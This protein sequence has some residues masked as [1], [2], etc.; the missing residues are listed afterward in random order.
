M[1]KK[2]RA[3][4]GSEITM[5]DYDIIEGFDLNGVNKGNVNSGFGT[6]GNT[7]KSSSKNF[8][9]AGQDYI[10]DFSSVTS[11]QNQLNGSSASANEIVDC[12]PLYDNTDDVSTMV[13]PYGS[14]ATDES[15][16]MFMTSSFQMFY[17]LIIAFIIAFSVPGMYKSYFSVAKR[18]GSTDDIE[19]GN[20]VTGS[21]NYYFM[22]Y[23]FL[24]FL[25]VLLDAGIVTKS[26]TEMSFAMM[27]LLYTMCTYMFTLV[28]RGMMEK[29]DR[30]VYGYFDSNINLSDSL[31]LYGKFM[32]ENFSVTYSLG[33]PII[34][35]AIFIVLPIVFAKDKGM[36][37]LPFGPL[38]A[39]FF[40]GLFMIL[41][42]FG[43]FF[44][45][46]RS[47]QASEIII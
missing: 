35:I 42:T 40:F 46:S 45:K 24:M 34:L 27:L 15:T 21:T 23:A 25:G 7:V 5:N 30:S 1:N 17:T 37:G 29:H 31:F 11:M 14:A 33:V 19:Y 3:V 22:F 47:M 9:Q 12:V 43:T 16:K 6:Y 13:V 26:Q 2:G 4:I 39:L 36:K 18:V 32:S 10:F 41:C 8:D 44:N 38:I 28:L 20:R